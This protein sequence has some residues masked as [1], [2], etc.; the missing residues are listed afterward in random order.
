MEP[1]RSGN[2]GWA[3]SEP[4]QNDSGPE[5]D[6]DGRDQP[7]GPGGAD[8][9]DQD[10]NNGC[11][12]DDD[13]EDDNE[14][15]CGGKGGQDQPPPTITEEPPPTTTT[16]PPENGVLGESGGDAE[17]KGAVAAAPGQPAVE[18]SDDELAFTGASTLPL[19]ALVFALT[20]SGS[21]TLSRV[22]DAPVGSS[23]RTDGSE[24]STWGLGSRSDPDITAF[25]LRSRGARPSL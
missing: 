21:L 9:L 17:V 14:G 12:N 10:G 16:E 8:K 1:G 5:R 6:V 11:G 13:F 15:N 25:P 23:P 2:M 19:V 22:A 3:S 18:V 4:D 20:A 7:G 24:A